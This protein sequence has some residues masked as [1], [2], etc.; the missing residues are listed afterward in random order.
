ML[1][2][3]AVEDEIPNLEERVQHI[4]TEQVFGIAITELTA[5]LS[6]R[7]LYCS[8]KANGKYAIVKNINNSD[9]NIRYIPGNHSWVGERCEFCGVNKSNFNRD[10][11]LDSHAYEF[12][13]TKNPE[14]IFNMKFDV[15]IY[16]LLH[17]R[18]L[19]PIEV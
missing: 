1:P 10:D 5:L 16:I 7:S 13:H 18:I 11:E 12:I 19:I 14:E 17:Q 9:G 3:V 15:I 2:N 6:R 8:K 4:L